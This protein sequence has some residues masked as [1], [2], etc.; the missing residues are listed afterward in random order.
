MR[1]YILIAAMLVV[2]ASVQAG[3]PR[4]LSTTDGSSTAQIQTAEASTPDT[5]AVDPAPA[6]SPAQSQTQTQTIQG[7]SEQPNA[8]LDKPTQDR[9]VIRKTERQRR[10]DLE[11]R[12]IDG[13][14]RH[15][16]YW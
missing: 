16:I 3:A 6:N 12:V 9:P 4:G 10:D 11:T 8:Q 2:P 5:R 1:P 13:L 14:H 15:G 7:K